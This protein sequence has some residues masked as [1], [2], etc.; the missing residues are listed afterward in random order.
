MMNRFPFPLPAKH[1][2]CFS[3]RITILPTRLLQSAA[4]ALCPVTGLG[5]H[6]H[7]SNKCKLTVMMTNSIPSGK[8][9]G[10]PVNRV[11][12]KGKFLYLGSEKFYMKGVTYGT[13]APRPDG[14]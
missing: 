6:A 2:F 3:T 14:A 11:Y 8:F 13:F 1:S 7:R 9:G 10:L 4:V 12:R 5:K